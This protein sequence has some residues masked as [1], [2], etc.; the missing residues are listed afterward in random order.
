MPAT[1]PSQLQVPHIPAHCCCCI[2]SAGAPGS[3]IRSTV[4]SSFKSRGS[5]IYTSAYT[6]YSGT[7]SER[8]V[9]WQCG[10]CDAIQD[11]RCQLHQPAQASPASGG[12][13]QNQ[14]ASPA[15][16]RAPDPLPPAVAT[17]HV[18]GAAALYAAWHLDTKG[19]MPSA[20]AIKQ[21]IL[22]SAEPTPSL[23][24]RCVSNGRLNVARLLGLEP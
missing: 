17:P 4:P 18:S 15:L 1:S 6:S 8:I 10:G 23:S 14:S 20:A 13:N 19:T 11:V 2:N 21:A 3:G 22:S 12:F 16:D 5:I 9:L 24:G 7:S